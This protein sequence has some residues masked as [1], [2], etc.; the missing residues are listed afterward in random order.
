MSGNRDRGN[1]QLIGGAVMIAIGAL[2][3]L[4][5][6]WFFDIG[7]MFRYYWPCVL[8]LI[9]VLQLAGRR[10]RS[11]SWVGPL[12]LI[13]LGIIFQLERLDVF[14]WRM[15]N[16]WP[17]ILIGIGFALLADR[18]RQIAHPPSS[19]VPP[20]DGPSTPDQPQIQA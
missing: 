2:F 12:T 6:V 18:L 4:D 16:L 1:G 13:I 10:S 19:T 5:R 17:L 9:G 11:R 15:R 8:I 20:P 3:L 14:N 7:R